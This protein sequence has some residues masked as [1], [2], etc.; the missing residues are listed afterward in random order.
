MTKEKFKAF[1]KDHKRE[2]AIGAVVVAGTVCTVVGVK[3]IK[4][5]RNKMEAY[6]EAFEGLN[7][8]NN[9]LCEAMSGC[10]QYALMTYDDVCR[11]AAN[12]HLVN[13]RLIDADG[14]IVEVKN[15]IAFGNKVEP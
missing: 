6:R 9:D 12:G 1:V 13:N 15:F 11:A 8:F 3:G 7:Q 2:I 4:V 5:H 10:S 14:D